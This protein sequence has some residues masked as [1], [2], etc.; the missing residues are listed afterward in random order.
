LSLS[1]GVPGRRCVSAA[2]VA[3]QPDR[4]SMTWIRISAGEGGR[5][6]PALAGIQTHSEAARRDGWDSGKGGRAAFQQTRPEELASGAAA[7]HEAGEHQQD[8]CPQ[9]GHQPPCGLIRIIESHRS[10][11]EAADERT[12]YAEQDCYDE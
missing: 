12:S 3:L 6:R 5:R 9:D 1:I 11:E 7:S 8:D 10:P 2:R 4:T